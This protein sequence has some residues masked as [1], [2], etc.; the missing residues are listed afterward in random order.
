MLRCRKSNR[1]SHRPGGHDLLDTARNGSVAALGISV[2]AH[3]VDTSGRPAFTQRQV[4]VQYKY[5]TSFQP[6]KGDAR[7][8]RRAISAEPKG[9]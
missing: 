5:R 4:S 7:L 9:G 8:G 1:P 2:R 6:L 3:D